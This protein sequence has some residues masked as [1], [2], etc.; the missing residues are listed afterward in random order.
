MS[1]SGYGVRKPLKQ[2]F[3]ANRTLILGKAAMQSSEYLKLVS[4][5]GVRVQR[6]LSEGAGGLPQASEGRGNRKG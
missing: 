5:G 3:E 4:V 2:G 6:N 1:N